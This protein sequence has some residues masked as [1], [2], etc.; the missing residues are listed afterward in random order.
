MQVL[1]AVGNG[2]E[3]RDLLLN[4]RPW[5]SIRRGKLIAARKTMSSETEPDGVTGGS[6]DVRS[7]MGVAT[8]SRSRE[9]VALLIRATG[10]AWAIRMT[11]ARRK[12]S[13]LLYHD[14]SPEVMERHLR[15]LTSRYA[16]VSLDVVVD[17][18]RARDW[19]RIP[20][21]AVCITF[22]DG[23]RGNARL[24]ELF[25]R[26]GVV[27]TLLQ[28]SPIGGT[29]PHFWFLDVA[30]PEPYKGLP[31]TL[32]LAE[33]GRAG[34]S[35]DRDHGEQGRQALSRSELEAL[36]A[37]VQFG[38]HTQWHPVLTMC[39]DDECEREI[40]DSK[41]DVEGLVGRPCRHFSYPNGDYTRRELELVRR[42]GFASARTVDIGWNDARTDPYRLK[43]LGV[44]DDATV[45]R[46]AADL[47]GIPGYL[48][49]LARGSWRG[50][51]RPFLPDPGR[52]A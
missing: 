18:I 39:D 40:V 11:L 47:S 43:I 13:I 45:N 27:A 28:S 7:A 19:S 10:V 15:F 26:F 20:R 52:H 3:D 14:P 50:R 44:S 29:H 22:D 16:I 36:G 23:H 35:P 34:Y 5:C 21:G 32:R 6:V 9:L 31:S 42:A 4:R 25:R 33:L 12:A 49:H 37:H 24:L 1:P 48:G 30:D 46:L 38:A 2:A 51:R 41:A 8:P 17:A